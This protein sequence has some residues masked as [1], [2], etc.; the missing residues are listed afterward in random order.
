M[1]GAD[2]AFT[3]EEAWLDRHPDAVSLHLDQFPANPGRLKNEALAEK[4][5][6]VRQVRRVVT[7]ALEI[8]RAQKVIGSS[9]EAV[10]V[11]TLDDAVLEAAISDVDMAEM[12]I[13]ATSSSPTQ[14]PGRRLRARRRQGG[15]RGGREGRGPRIG[16]M[17]AF[18]AL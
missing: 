17:R 3:M 10:P 1:A 13:P 6:K 15:R 7:G 18:M 4:W 11:V 12:A 16:Q 2:A 5:R 9:L 8:A 14:G